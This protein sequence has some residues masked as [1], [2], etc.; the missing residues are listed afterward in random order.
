MIK[1]HPHAKERLA[2]RGAT[3]EEII[4]TVE[5]GEVFPVKFNRTGFRKNFSYNNIW[6]K[7]YYTTKQIEVFAVQE[8]DNWLVITVITKFF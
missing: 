6:N 5:Q 3:I 4:Q 7:K 2:E 1:F 8:G